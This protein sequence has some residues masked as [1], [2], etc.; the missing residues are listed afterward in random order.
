MCVCES[1]EVTLAPPPRPLR[2]YCQGENFCVRELGGAAGSRGRECLLRLPP[3]VDETVERNEKEF[4]VHVTPPSD[5][6]FRGS[7]GI[8]RKRKGKSG[9]QRVGSFGTRPR[10]AHAFCLTGFLAR[11][12]CC[13]RPPPWS[14]CSSMNLA[15]PLSSLS[16]ACNL[17]SP[18]RATS[19][20]PADA[21]P[22]NAVRPP[23]H[24]SA[25]LPRPG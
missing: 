2:K 23:A 10:S 14:A 5:Q 1:P 15:L 25:I 7:G 22:P 17:Q 6:G 13:A 24:R 18:P 16:V 3:V 8:D 21:L 12:P 20:W 9:V 19:R 4:E 11:R